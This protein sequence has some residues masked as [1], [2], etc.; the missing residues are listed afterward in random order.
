MSTDQPPQT[1]VAHGQADFGRTPPAATAA[2]EDPEL[3]ILR[4]VRGSFLAI[5]KMSE[6]MRGDLAL[7]GER[8]DRL[9][10]KSERARKLIKAKMKAD[11]AAAAAARLDQDESDAMPP[12][13]P[14]ASLPPWEGEG[15]G[16][17]G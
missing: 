9:L 11:K 1:P 10:E 16:G 8:F 2:A 13:P 6:S 12:P 17:G 15:G 5:L 14:P 7:L 4:Q 3:T